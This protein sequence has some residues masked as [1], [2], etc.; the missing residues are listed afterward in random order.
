MGYDQIPDGTVCDDGRFYTV[1]DRCV[2]GL[3]TGKSVNLCI[4]RDIVCTVPNE[5]YD[6]GYCDPNTGACTEAIPAAGPR[7]CNDGDPASYNDSCV[8]GVCLG[9]IPG[10]NTEFVTLG[11]GEYTVE[12]PIRK[13][14]E[15]EARLDR[16][17]RRSGSYT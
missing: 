11:E 6:P 5:C 16:C 13:V 17:A 7:P 14:V 3:C 8:D 10:L 1:E 2:G 12:K 15:N 4:E 9:W